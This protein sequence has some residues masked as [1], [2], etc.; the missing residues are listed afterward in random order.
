MGLQEILAQI[1]HEIVRLKQARA[2]LDGG[3]T[4]SPSNLPKKR[5]LT[6][7][8]RQRI[9]EAVRRRWAREKK[10]KLAEAPG[11]VNQRLFVGQVSL[12]DLPSLTSL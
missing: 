2:L 4:S 3:R 11:W 1:D 7:E 12:P 10:N 6:P 5:N 8:G 9:A